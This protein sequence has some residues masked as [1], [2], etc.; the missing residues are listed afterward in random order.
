MQSTINPSTRTIYRNDWIWS[1]WLKLRM[2]SRFDYKRFRHMEFIE[3]ETKRPKIKG[4]LAKLL[5]EYHSYLPVDTNL[6]TYLKYRRLAT[7]LTN[8]FDQRPRNS[9]TR[10][11]NFIEILT[12]ELAKKQGYD[13][14]VLRLQYNPNRDQSMKGDDMLGFKVPDDEEDKNIILIGE[15]KFR[16]D[17]SKEAVKDAYDG[18]KDKVRSGPISMEFTASILSRE[19]DKQKAAEIMRLRKQILEHN[20]IITQKHLLFLGTVG[21]PTNPFKY[22]EEYPH[23]L[24]SDLIAV[25]VIFKA[26]LVNWLDQV[27]KQE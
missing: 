21:Q 14:P 7:T 23:D 19:G 15:A 16:T 4:A 25:N 24:L 20:T 18:L 6:L 3:D 22:L 1:T 5:Y 11:G 27:Y 10:S 2:P 26:D 9:V 17:F 13:I 8:S 12:C